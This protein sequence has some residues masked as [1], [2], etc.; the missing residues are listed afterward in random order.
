MNQTLLQ[1]ISSTENLLTA[2]DKLDKHKPDSHG[3]SGLSIKVFGQ[4]LPDKINSISLDLSRGKFKFS[5]NRAVLIP[6]NNEKFRPLQVPEIQDRLVLKSIAIQLE[7][8]FLET[9]NRSQGISFAYQKGLGIKN[10]IDCI[11][12]HYES[13]NSFVLE[14]D[15][16]NFFGEVNKTRLLEELIF[17]VLPDN[18]INS[19]IKEGLNQDIGGLDKIP[20]KLRHYF[21]N[22]KKGI[23]QG[24]ALSPLLSNIYLSPFDLRLKEKG[25]RLV[26]YADD[27]IILCDNHD[28]CEDAYKD[29]IEILEELELK[30]HAKDAENAKTRIVDLSKEEFTFLSITFNGEN[31]FPSR[32]SVDY[33]KNKVS[34][35]CNRTKK[36]HTVMSVL[37]KLQNTLDGW[38]SAF[39]YTDVD[40]YSEEIDVHINKQIFLGLR[41]FEWKFSRQSLGKLPYKYRQAGGSSEC[42][43]DLQ[44][45]SSGINRTSEL[46]KQ[47][48]EKKTEEA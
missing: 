13:G 45:D 10:A 41:R 20:M 28:R 4:N 14:S 5:P 43:S 23:P 19:L 48:R 37:I 1:K 31:F 38:V 16:I 27:F 26:R 25:Y 8:I 47:K 15:L 40:R 33:F 9:I 34:E 21:D 2:W 39:Y 24:N 30:I 18:T 12:Y 36:E 22:V 3:L 32:D 44:R 11:K 7:E 6:K 46:I 29:C 42:L 17:P 35:I